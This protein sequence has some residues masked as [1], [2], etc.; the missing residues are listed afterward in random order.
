[1]SACSKKYE[2][3]VKTVKIWSKLRGANYFRIFPGMFGSMNG[4]IRRDIFKKLDIYWILSF[5]GAFPKNST[6]CLTPV[7]MFPN[8][9]ILKL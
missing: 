4:Q 1:M 2:Y 5:C 9:S 7:V 6:L 3:L 8:A